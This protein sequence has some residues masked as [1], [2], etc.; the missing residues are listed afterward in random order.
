MIVN[1]IFIDYLT[2]ETTCSIW[3][4]YL[5]A[6]GGNLTISKKQLNGGLKSELHEA[7]FM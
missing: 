2:R 7:L 4:M 5:Y 6:F 1:D 3:K